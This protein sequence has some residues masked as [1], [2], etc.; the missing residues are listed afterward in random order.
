M[1]HNSTCYSSSK[2]E[3]TINESDNDD[4]FESIYSMIISNVQKYFGKGLRWIV[5][6]VADHTVHIS[7]CKLLRGSSYI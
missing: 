3:T 2:A 7:K 1:K 6:S 4:A 5:N